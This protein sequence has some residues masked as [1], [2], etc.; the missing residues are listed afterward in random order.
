MNEKVKK[1][2]K[3][4][5]HKLDWHWDRPFPGDVGEDGRWEISLYSIDDL[6]E[7]GY[8]GYVAIAELENGR[9]TVIFTIDKEEERFR[10]TSPT[11]QDAKHL[12]DTL[13]AANTR[14]FL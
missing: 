8:V 9:W 14:T 2:L 6:T 1:K 3:G 10:F 5:C 13:L 4:F 7:D 11:L 12:L